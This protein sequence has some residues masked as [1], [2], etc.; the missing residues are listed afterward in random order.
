[1]CIERDKRENLLDF[2]RLYIY[3]ESIHTESLARETVQFSSISFILSPIGAR[4]L[5]T[6]VFFFPHFHV[7]GNTPETVHRFCEERQEE[8]MEANQGVYQFLVPKITVGMRNDLCS[9]HLYRNSNPRSLL[10][11]AVSHDYPKGGSHLL[12]KVPHMERLL[13]QLMRVEYPYAVASVSWIDQIIGLFCR[14]SSL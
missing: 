11:L 12:K 3:I 5:K 13:S 4:T 14:I 10:G 1:M 6:S 7:Q 9:K 8:E 2:Q